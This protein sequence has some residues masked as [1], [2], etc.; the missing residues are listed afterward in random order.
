MIIYCGSKESA[1]EEAQ[2]QET[3]TGEAR[4]VTCCKAPAGVGMSSCT[5]QVTD[6]IPLLGECYD[7]SGIRHG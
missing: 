7:T 2:R 5:W 6:K 4:W 1:I 3:H